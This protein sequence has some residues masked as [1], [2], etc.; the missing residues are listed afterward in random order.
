MPATVLSN[1]IRLRAGDVSR[2]ANQYPAHLV[3]RLTLPDGTAI[4]IRPIR[5]EDAAIEA[6]FVRGL[7]EE[8]RYFRFMDSVREL[9][10]DMLARFTRIDYD[11]HMA[12]IATTAAGGREIQIAVARYVVGPADTECE[13]A[14]VV[15]DAWQRRGVGGLLMRELM[16]AARLKGLTRM[17][18]EVLAGNRKM[19]E[20]ITRLGFDATHDPQDPRLMRVEK[21]L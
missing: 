14:I 16:A 11:R 18:G 1:A 17:Y 15:A 19:L 7:S 21:R 2:V 5:A 6:E 4:T 3:K 9:S 13:F 12:L 20:F 8:S 10:A